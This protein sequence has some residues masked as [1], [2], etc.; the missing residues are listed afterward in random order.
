MTSFNT[1]LNDMSQLC[2][3][4]ELLLATTAPAKQHRV[5]ATTAAGVG[6]EAREV[7]VHCR[8]ISW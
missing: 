5:L 3:L 1:A 2:F 8:F 4:R 6:V 7:R